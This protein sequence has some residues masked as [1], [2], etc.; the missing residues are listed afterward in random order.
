MNLEKHH[1]QLRRGGDERPVNILL[2][3]A[4]IHKWAQEHPA[5]AK[6]LG[7]IVSQYDDPAEISVVIPN[8]ILSGN[9]AKKT[10]VNLT[11]EDRKKRLTTQ[12]RTPK[13]EEN[14]LPELLDLCKEKLEA[15]GMEWKHEDQ[16]DSY[17]YVL[18][19]V[20][21]DWLKS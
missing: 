2:M 16:R 1:R 17:Y 6:D 20:L 12:I 15:I 14:V 10:R 4:E 11:K 21:A 9:G 3:E 7:W 13:D 5:E 18:V 19:T 8:K